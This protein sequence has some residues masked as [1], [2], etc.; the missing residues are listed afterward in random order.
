ML[1]LVGKSRAQ[2]FRNS[3]HPWSSLL[4]KEGAY[5]S[6]IFLENDCT[7]LLVTTRNFADNHHEIYLKE[8]HVSG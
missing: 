3:S 8:D 4:V 2:N 7:I 1:V 5:Y 6:S